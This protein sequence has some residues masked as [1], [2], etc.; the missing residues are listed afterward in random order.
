MARAKLGQPLGDLL[1]HADPHALGRL[2]E[3]QQLRPTQQRAADREHLALAAG[4]RARRSAPAAAPAWERS[5]APRRCRRGPLAVAPSS[6]FS[7]TV[8][9]AEDRVLPAARS[10][11]RAAPA[12]R[13]AR[14]SPRVPSNRIEPA[15]GRQFA[16]KR[17]QQRR[18]A[19]AV[20]PQHRHG[21]PAGRREPQAEQHLAAAVAGVEAAHARGSG[22]GQTRLVIDLLDLGRVLD[23]PRRRPRPAPGPGRARSAGR[24][25]S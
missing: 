3:H 25:C 13:S 24:R 6:R 11:C 15:I 23:L 7:R 4:Q 14:L 17:F 1:D 20:A 2:V 9:L 8:S 16:G 5:R 12:V 22:P 21:A 18:L 10:R 19:R